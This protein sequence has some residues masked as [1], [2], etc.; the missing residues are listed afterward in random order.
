MQNQKTSL[1]LDEIEIYKISERKLSE[2]QA[3]NGIDIITV[4]PT[5][6]ARNA[7]LC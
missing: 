3:Q 6:H 4:L 5:G 1:G 2:A 7:L